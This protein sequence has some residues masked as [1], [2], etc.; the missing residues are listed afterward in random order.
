MAAN[1]SLDEN[2][3]GIPDECEG[4]HRGWF[5]G[6]FGSPEEL[7]EA[8]VEYF[9]WLAGQQWLAGSE[10]SGSEKFQLMT[11]KME[12]LGLPVRNWTVLARSAGG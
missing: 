6:E 12:E 4:G 10:L 9:D 7:M 2:E 1:V 11:E 5:G 3:N 8:W